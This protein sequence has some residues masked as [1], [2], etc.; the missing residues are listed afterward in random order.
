M[1][2]GREGKEGEK[3]REGVEVVTKVEEATTEV[4]IRGT[5]KLAVM[6]PQELKVEVVIIVHQELKVDLVTT[7]R[8][9]LEGTKASPSN[10]SKTAN[11]TKAAREDMTIPT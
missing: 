10:N 8:A 2:V 4:K 9:H 5:R 6:E 3:E 7:I 11:R 1:V